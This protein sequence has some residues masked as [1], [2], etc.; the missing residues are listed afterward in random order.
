MMRYGY[1]DE[2]SSLTTVCTDSISVRQLR[3]QDV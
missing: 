3:R 2:N 1:E